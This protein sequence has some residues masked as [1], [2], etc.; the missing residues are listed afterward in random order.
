MLRT[1]FEHDHLSITE[2]N[3][4]LD[5][6]QANGTDGNDNVVENVRAHTRGQVS[7]SMG[8]S[9]YSGLAC[10]AFFGAFHLFE[11]TSSFCSR[12][13]SRSFLDL[14]CAPFSFPR[15]GQ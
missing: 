4:S 10:W 9:R 13:P 5:L 6:A 7:S 8:T 14:P 2:H 1:A 11:P 12:L 15:R 3:L